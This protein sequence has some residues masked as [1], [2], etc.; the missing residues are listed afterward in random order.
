MQQA[1]QVL[2]NIWYPQFG[3]TVGG[4][5]H[6]G[7]AAEKPLC[8]ASQSYEYTVSVSLLT[9]LLIHSRNYEEAIK[10]NVINPLPLII[11]I[12]VL[13][14]HYLALNVLCT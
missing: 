13:V 9:V 6:Q 8:R 11:S 5:A 4:M 10:T 1:E 2:D 3:H 14:E 7:H 12:L